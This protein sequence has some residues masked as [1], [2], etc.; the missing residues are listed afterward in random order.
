MTYSSWTFNEKSMYQ[1]AMYQ[2]DFSF[3]IR[4]KLVVHK[5]SKHEHMKYPC[6]IC[7]FLANTQTLGIIQTYSR[8][9]IV[10]PYIL[11]TRTLKKRPLSRRYDQKRGGLVCAKPNQHIMANILCQGFLF[12][13]SFVCVETI[14]PSWFFC[15]QTTL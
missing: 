2:C 9:D 13:L 8:I 7:D 4:S 5:L 11:F 14:C 3:K 6:T 15:I 12:E 10:S 1:W